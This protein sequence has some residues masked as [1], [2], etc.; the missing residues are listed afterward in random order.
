MAYLGECCGLWGRL[1]LC[2]DD[3]PIPGIVKLLAEFTRLIV[4]DIVELRPKRLDSVVDSLL[5]VG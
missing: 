5:A 1:R 4:A 2:T 3:D